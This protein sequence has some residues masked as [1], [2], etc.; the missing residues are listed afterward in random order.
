MTEEKD[1]NREP[2]K[3]RNPFVGL[4]RVISSVVSTVITLVLVGCA[5]VAFLAFTHPDS[6]LPPEWNPQ[7][8][9]VVDSEVTLLT[10][11]KLRRAISNPDECRAVLAEAA[12]MSV[13]EPFEVSSACHVRNRVEVTGVGQA[14]VNSVD[15]ACGTALRLAMWERHGIQPAAAEILGTQ[16][17]QIQQIGSYNCRQV[18]TTQGTSNAWSTHATADAIDI[19]GFELAD[20]R[21]IRLIDDWNGQGNFAQ[22][23]RAT[24]DS[25]C[26]WFVT[27][28]SPD[29][30]ALHADH[31]HL[32]NRGWGTCR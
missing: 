14:R 3:K 21:Q 25:A 24:R 20:G 2:K 5:L 18:R 10:M 22:F 11:W 23:L 31:F 26:D 27:T 29:Y 4:F 32:Q 1:Q 30:N 13:L 7:A 8:R 28:L 6:T 9:L 15:T 12:Q 16:V 17:R 19:S